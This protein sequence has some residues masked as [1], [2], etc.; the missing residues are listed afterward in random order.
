MVRPDQVMQHPV[1][2]TCQR[3]PVQRFAMTNSPIAP[4]VELDTRHLRVTKPRG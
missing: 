2:T 1:G 4:I 3:N